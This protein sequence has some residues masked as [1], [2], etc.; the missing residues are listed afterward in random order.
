MIYQTT[1]D[2]KMSYVIVNTET[3]H[4]Y[5]PKLYQPRYYE[6]E[7]GAKM[8]CTKLNKQENKWRVMTLADYEAMPQPMVE[9]MNLMTGKKFLE[10]KNTPSYMS[11]SSESYWSR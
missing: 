6:T 1:K 8:V 4:L 11:P 10:P 7:H 9:R 3:D 5:T 2:R